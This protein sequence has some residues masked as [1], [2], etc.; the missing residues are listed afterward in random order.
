[1]DENEN[2]N[3]TGNEQE[4]EN[5]VSEKTKKEEKKEKKDR[6]LKEIESKN[7][8]IAKLKEQL[9]SFKDKYYHA[10]ADMDNQRKQY[11]KE[12]RQS[13]KYAS[14]NLAE[15]LI[16]S[17]EMFSMVVESVDHLP[18]EVQAYAQGFN[19]VYRQMVQALESEGVNE[20]KVKIGDEFNHNIH[21]AMEIQEVEDEA[22][23][24]KITKIVRKGYMI[25]DRLIKPVTVVVGK[26]KNDE[27]KQISEE[28]NQENENKET[29]ANA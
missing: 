18:N 24:N 8:E 9:E 26:L 21:S 10:I 13:L 29:Q 5:T 4:K 16:P 6:F 27:E 12:Y 23:N 17:F 1:M 3:E 7:D 20:I 2:L 11:D 14:Q 22:L 19:M 25:H 15:K 28:V